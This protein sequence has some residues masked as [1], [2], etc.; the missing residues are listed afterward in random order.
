MIA[1]NVAALVFCIIICLML[2]K[3]TLCN[4]VSI[5]LGKCSYE[6]YLIHFN[7]I[8]IAQQYIPNKSLLSISIAIITLVL[9][10]VTYSIRMFLE[11]K[12]ERI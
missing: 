3:I 4:R 1:R 9:A 10:F 6:I 2:Q 7:V 5:W 8:F 11:S 12:L